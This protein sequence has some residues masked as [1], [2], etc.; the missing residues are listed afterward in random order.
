MYSENKNNG[1]ESFYNTFRQ[2]I[3]HNLDMEQLQ[4]LFSSFDVVFFDKH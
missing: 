4:V 2:L 1:V 3:L